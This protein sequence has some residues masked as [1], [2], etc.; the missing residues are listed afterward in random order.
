ML[1]NH[2][3]EERAIVEQPDR[4]KSI[5]SPGGQLADNAAITFL[6]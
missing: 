1:V 2:R 4:S 6:A 3:I 5:A